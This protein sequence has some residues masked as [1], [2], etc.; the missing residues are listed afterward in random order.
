M[1]RSRRT[2]AYFAERAGLDQAEALDRLN[3]LGLRL[4]KESA[5][6]PKNK[7]LSAE[8]I[9]GLAKPAPKPQPAKA[10]DRRERRRARLDARRAQ[11]A[12]RKKVE[13]A[14][15]RRPNLIGKDQKLFFLNLADLKKI[16][17]TLVEDF[18]SSRD[19]ISPP[20]EKDLSLLESALMRCQTSL[21]HDDKYPTAPMSGAAL[22]HSLIHNHPFHNGN[23]RTALVSLLVF[24]DKNG[25][26]LTTEQDHLFDFLLKAGAHDLVDRSA[27]P[28]QDFADAEVNAIARWLTQNLKRT[29]HPH[30]H[31]KFHQLRTILQR[32]GCTLDPGATGSKMNIYRDGKRC[33]IA[34]YGEGRHVDVDSIAKTRHDL[35]LDEMHG[36]DTDMFYNAED[37]LPAFITKY[38]K[39]LNRLAKT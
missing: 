34:Y 14:A 18:S 15:P 28:T 30:K 11:A 2:V 38:R 3:Q 6:I 39:T 21:G 23:K 20:G 5:V 22:M 24:L 1:A 36:Y 27:I 29:E 10:Q 35:A 25:W 13:R 37:R 12:E 16:H 17:W 31:L 7:V 26:T 4:P 19:P 33:Q 32:Y 8:R 9:L